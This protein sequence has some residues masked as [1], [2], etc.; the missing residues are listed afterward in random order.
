MKIKLLFLFLILALTKVFATAQ[1][2]DK[3]IIDG[4]KYDLLNS[5]MERYFEKHPEFH[6]IYSGKIEMLN[7]HINPEFPLPFS[8][9]NYRGYIATLELKNNQ[10]NLVDIKVPNLDSE[11]REYISVFKELFGTQKVN[12]NYNGILVIPT[13]E[14]EEFI[15]FGYA[16]IYS[17]YKLVTIKND[18]VTKTK[19]LNKDEFYQFKI[20]QFLAFKKSPEYKKAVNEYLESWKNDKEMEL[21]KEA[22]KHL[23]PKQKRDL[24][25]EYE[26]PPSTEYL[27]NFFFIMGKMDHI[28]VD[29]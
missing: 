11:E 14:L 22:T 4:K 17:Q 8:T 6:P 29:Y 5:P 21:S 28:E 27:D 23:T 16:S 9:G 19:D 24:E 15:N 1:A 18:H 12:I 7:K 3:I 25:K 2:P 13:G 10:L 26:T 20:K